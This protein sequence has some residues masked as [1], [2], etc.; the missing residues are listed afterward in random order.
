MLLF[1]KKD[2]ETTYVAIIRESKIT[3]SKRIFLEYL[4]TTTH[5]GIIL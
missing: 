4:E 5:R 2:M 3:P 1:K